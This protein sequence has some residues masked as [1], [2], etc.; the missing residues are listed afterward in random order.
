MR[1]IAKSASLA[2]ATGAMLASLSGAAFAGGD[3][4]GNNDNND[5]VNNCTLEGGIIELPINLNIL[6]VGEQDASDSLDCIIVD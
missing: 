5:N 1:L 3:E 4:G 2:I 6:A